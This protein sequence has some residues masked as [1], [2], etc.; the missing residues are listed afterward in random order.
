VSLAVHVTVVVPTGKTLPDAGAQT[1]GRSPSTRSK[2]DAVNVTT[3]P[4]GSSVSTAISAGTVTTGGVVSRMV[5]AK[6]RV[7]C[8]AS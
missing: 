8:S 5:T 2:A 1:T 6:S 7:S 3:A 4:P